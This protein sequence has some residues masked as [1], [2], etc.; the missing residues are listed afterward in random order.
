MHKVICRHR[1]RLC[2]IRCIR[3]LLIIRACWNLNFRYSAVLLLVTGTCLD[4]INVPC[5]RERSQNVNSRMK[6]FQYSLLLEH[7]RISKIK[8]NTIVL[9]HIYS[10]QIDKKSWW[11]WF[12]QIQK[13]LQIH[14]S[15]KH[16]KISAVLQTV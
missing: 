3:S 5:T 4:F 8:N 10:P 16:I 12:D 2:S 14:R 15:I 6:L 13:R 7:L 11:L 1:C 9:N